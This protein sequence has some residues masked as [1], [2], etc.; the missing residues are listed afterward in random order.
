MTTKEH[1]KAILI[2]ISRRLDDVFD[3]KKLWEYRKR[4]PK[5]EE[6]TLIVVYDSG[7]AHAIVGEFFVQRVLRGTIDEV[8]AKTIKE[9]TSPETALRE[10]FAGTEICSALRVEEPKRYKTPIALSEIRKLV[11]NFAPPQGYIFL[12]K[13]DNKIKPLFD[14][15]MYLREEI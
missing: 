12:R 9:T 10:Y 5:I 3:G 2:S 15:V 13:G 7:K 11:P 1:E 4:P 8:I 6:K 14:R